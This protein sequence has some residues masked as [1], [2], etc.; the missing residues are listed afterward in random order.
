MLAG[1]KVTM[2]MKA[3]I[4]PT[5]AKMANSFMGLISETVLEPKETAVVTVARKRAA[6]TETVVRTR[7]S[8]LVL[9]YRCLSSL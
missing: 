6:P 1:T 8:L 5:R 4:I 2:M 3:L 7:A 9:L